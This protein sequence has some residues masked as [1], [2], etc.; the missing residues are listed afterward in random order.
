MILLEDTELK[1]KILI[2]ISSQALFT[3]RSTL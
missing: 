2:V 3:L 1:P